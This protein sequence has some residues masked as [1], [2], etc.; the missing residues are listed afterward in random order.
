VSEIA[1]SDARDRAGVP[2]GRALAAWFP[3]LVASFGIA[4]AVAFLPFL[5]ELP[6]YL[7]ATR[8]IA[9]GGRVADR[10]YPVGYPVIL[11]PSYALAGLDGVIAFQAVLYAVSL[12]LFARLLARAGL[13]R[14]VIALATAALACHPYLLLDIQ[15]INDNAVNVPLM[16]ALVGL[17]VDA[18]LWR[19][20]AA[21]A[22]LGAAIGA[23]VA[24]RPNALVL[25]VLPL[26]VMARERRDLARPLVCALVALASFAILSR[27]GTG[28]WLFF[29]GNGPYNLFAGTNAMTAA[30]LRHGYNGEASV[31]PALAAAGIATDAPLAVPADVYYGLVARFVVDAPFQALALVG[32]K[33]LN[34]FRPDWQF[35]DDAYEAAAQTVVALPLVLW[36]IAWSGARGYRTSRRGGVI[37]A[38]ALLFVLPFALTN[39]DPRFRLPLDIVLLLEAVTVFG[40]STWPRRLRALGAGYSRRAY[41]SR[42]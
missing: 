1:G 19:A 33:I 21:P 18:R 29:P 40:L 36:L 22:A 38:V 28:E 10:F 15:R 6:P 14:V 24:I 12:W 11:A 16:L 34:L 2:P 39:S 31:A 7:D 3:W 30:A 37:V 17:T 9:A 23:F 32:L 27:V 13:D 26:A 4:A 41:T 35:A 25:A 8:V 20:P 42:S 5:A